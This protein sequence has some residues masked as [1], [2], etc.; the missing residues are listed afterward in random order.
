MG[1]SRALYV[2]RVLAVLL[3]V[4]FPYGLAARGGRVARADPPVPVSRPVT[5]AAGVLGGRRGQVD[6]AVARLRAVHGVRLYVVYV[7]DFSGLSAQEW[8]SQAALRSHL[9]RLDLLLAF[10]VGERRYAVSADSRFPLSSGELDAVAA[11]VIEPALRH[12]DWAGAAIGAAEEYG[13][14]LAERGKIHAA[15]RPGG[16]PGGGPGVA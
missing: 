5:D 10:S 14:T 15:D 1:A 4:A 16:G 3:S 6:R 11:T 8:A 13:A 2:V 7:K 12:G 9:G